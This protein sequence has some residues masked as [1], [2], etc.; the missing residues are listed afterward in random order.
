MKAV[1]L[2]IRPKWCELIASGQK[3]IEVRKTRP[4]IETPF[5]CY[6]YCTSAREFHMISEHMGASDEYL[7]LCE[8]KVSMSDGFE[9]FGREDYAGLNRKVIGEFVCDSIIKMQYNDNGY[10]LDGENGI[11]AHSCVPAKELYHYL[12]GAKPFL[13]HISNLKIYDRPRELGEFKQCHKCP[14]GDIKRCTEHEFSCN[15]EYA[16]HRAP[17]SWCYVEEAPACSK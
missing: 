6:I 7:H 12:Q 9:F 4:K 3:T 17:Q 10:G 2:S 14:Y 11:V 5:K 8:G 16:L 15:R 1:L 13:W